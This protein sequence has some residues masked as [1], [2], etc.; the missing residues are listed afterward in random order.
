MRRYLMRRI[1][2][3]VPVLFGV[4]LIVFALMYL[5]PS[6]PAQMMLGPNATPS[7]YKQMKADMGLDKPFIVQYFRF[8]FGYR[9]DVFGY[10]GL[11]FGDLGR[12]YVSNRNVFELILTSFP[13]TLVLATGALLSATLIGVPIGILS[14]TLPYSILDMVFTVLALLG[15]SMPVFWAAMVLIYTF[16]NNLRI[17]PAMSNPGQFASLVLPIVTLSMHSMAVIMRMTRSSMLEVMGQD[18]IRTA[19]V[20]G[21]DEKV[22]IFKHALRNA[23]IPVVTVA[24]LQFGQLLGGAVLTEKIF[25]YPGLG[26]IMVDAI[27]Q[28][29]TPQILGSVCFVALT[30]TIIN[31]LVDILYGFIDPRIKTMYMKKKKPAARPARSAP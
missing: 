12:S 1:L 19:R 13:N 20:K 30:F 18:Y 21:M 4:T 11:V 8:L 3:L 17:F 22:V 24:G 7:A 28:K 27:Y 6:D 10:R 31:L 9:H 26:T 23:L 14:A 2:M 25:S 15:A 5:T 29:D 16:A